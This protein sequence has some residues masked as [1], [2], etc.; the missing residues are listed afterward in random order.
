[1][2]HKRTRKPTKSDAE[3][4]AE[5]IAFEDRKARVTEMRARGAHVVCDAQW[6]IVTARRL[7]VFQ[8]LFEQRPNPAITQAQLD[9][10]RR[11]E[12]EMAMAEGVGLTGDNAGVRSSS[13]GAPGQNVSQRMVDAA[14][15]LEGVYARLG[16]TNK[17]LLVALLSPQFKGALLTRWREVVE[18]V[19]G[20]TNDRAQLGAVRMALT[21]LA[22]IYRTGNEA[23]EHQSATTYIGQM[24]M[25]AA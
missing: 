8:L 19:T 18:G 11:L 16:P 20:E 21:N 6:R 12:Q 14:R 5:R 2:A 9:A 15:R 22:V 3:L 10:V 13:E 17:V 24:N 7:D 1:M 25:R 4:E 23:A